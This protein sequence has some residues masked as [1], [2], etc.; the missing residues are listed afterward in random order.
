MNKFRQITENRELKQY[1]VFKNQLIL[2]QQTYCLQIYT[3]YQNIYIYSYD[4][5]YGNELKS[6]RIMPMNRNEIDSLILKRQVARY[7]LSQQNLE[8]QLSVLKRSLAMLKNDLRITIGYGENPSIH[9]LELQPAVL[10]SDILNLEQAFFIVSEDVKR[11]KV[12][13]EAI[14]NEIKMDQKLHDLRKEK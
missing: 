14:R 3:N 9:S 11:L 6:V 8:W 5:K 1:E 12:E 4:I 13:R 10:T 2:I 7:E